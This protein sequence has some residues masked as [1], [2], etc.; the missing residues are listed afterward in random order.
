MFLSS[1]YEFSMDNNFEKAAFQ[2]VTVAVRRRNIVRLVFLG[3]PSNN[4]EFLIQ[5]SFIGNLLEKV[6]QNKVPAY[7]YVSQ[8]LLGFG[9]L[10][11][12]IQSLEGCFSDVCAYMQLNGFPYVKVKNGDSYMLFLSSVFSKNFSLPVYK[13]TKAAFDKLKT[14]LDEEGFEVSDIVRQWNYIERITDV[15]FTGRQRYQEFNDARSRFYG[16]SFDD[17]GFPAATGI[18][19]K[20]GGVQI[21]VDVVKHAGLYSVRI[22]NPCQQSAYKY[23]S[24]VLVGDPSKTTPK[25]ERARLVTLLSGEWIYISGTAAIRGE[26]TFEADVTVQTRLSLENIKILLSCQ[27]LSVCGIEGEA[28]LQSLR[29][30]VRNEEDFLLVKQCLGN[31]FQKLEIIYIQADICRDNLLVEIEGMAKLIH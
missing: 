17:N 19:T 22:D 26:Q 2:L 6:F 27:N 16:H 21:E 29:V 8:P 12:E 9:H 1:H 13:Q 4:D 24:R 28:Q 10:A 31:S 5:H 25:F 23:S 20:C 15:E 11:L 30:Y 18:G 3:C 7:S 14:V